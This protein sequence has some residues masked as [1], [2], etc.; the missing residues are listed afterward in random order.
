M[1]GAGTLTGAVAGDPPWRYVMG[2][3][4]VV[5]DV[6]ERWRLDTV[7]IGGAVALLD[8]RVGSRGRCR[9]AARRA[10]V[11]LDREYV[12]VPTLGRPLFLAQDEARSLRWLIATQLAAP[13]GWPSFAGLAL[14][15]VRLVPTRWIG[16]LVPGRVVVGRRVAMG[17]RR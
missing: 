6:G 15:I 8:A 13:P 5:V 7:P 16:L 17:G 4:T 3:D 11:A 10:G 2:V 9:R 14:P 12:V 1:T